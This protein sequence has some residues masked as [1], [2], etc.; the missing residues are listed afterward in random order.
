MMIREAMQGIYHW[1]LI[2]LTLVV[3]TVSVV[4]ALRIAMLVV[5]HEDFVMGSYN[6][7]FAKF[8]KERF[9]NR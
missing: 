3:E 1:R 8:A 4:L 6:G 2:G 5:K 7:G 9:F